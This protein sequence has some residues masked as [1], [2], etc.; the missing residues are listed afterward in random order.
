MRR[1]GHGHLSLRPGRHR[2]P[3]RYEIDSGRSA[4]GSRTRHLFG[5]L[6]V[7]GTFAIRSGTVDIA[8]P[9]T[10]SSLRVEVDTASLRT[11][12]RRRDD[13]VRSARF[14]DAGRNP[15][16]VFVSATLDREAVDG[17]LTVGGVTRTVVLAVGLRAL[18]AR[19][20]TV[21]AT[22]SLDRGDFGVTAARGLAG[23]RLDVTAEITCVRG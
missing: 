20:F 6:P 23:T 1:R 4:T 7:R 22:T 18:S 19:S 9:L 15:V 3:G 11:G 14:L 2:E 16:M 12:R 10:D 8:E 21:R 17:V 5:L 13:A